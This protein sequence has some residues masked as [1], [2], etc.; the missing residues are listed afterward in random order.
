MGLFCF[1][2]LGFQC[3]QKCMCSVSVGF[4]YFFIGF[5]LLFVLSYSDLLVTLFYYHSLDICCF[6]RRDRKSVDLNGRQCG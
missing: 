3:V 4:L 5:F 2:F 6:K 1:I